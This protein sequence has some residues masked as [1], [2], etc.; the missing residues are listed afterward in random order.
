MS[1]IVSSLKMFKGYMFGC[2]CI[3]YAISHS[4]QGQLHWVVSK[5]E[6]TITQEVLGCGAYG[7]VK[8]AVF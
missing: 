7:E 5:E 3:L 4:Q 2:G 6:I 8:V 1:C